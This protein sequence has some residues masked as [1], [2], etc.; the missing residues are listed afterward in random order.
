MTSKQLQNYRDALIG[1]K[2]KVHDGLSYYTTTIDSV[3]AVSAR[4]P[5]TELW[6]DI[7]I[8]NGVKDPNWLTFH[9]TYYM[10]SAIEQLI[11]DKDH[12]VV[13]SEW[14]INTYGEPSTTQSYIQLI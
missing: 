10:A 12:K 1:H 6:T 14:R 3:D 11:S 9:N 13:M 2:L 4:V 5:M 8:I 7:V